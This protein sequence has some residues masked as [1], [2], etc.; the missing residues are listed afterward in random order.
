[1]LRQPDPES[2]LASLPWR[3]VGVLQQQGGDVL[4]LRAQVWGG[5][6]AKNV[7]NMT[8]KSCLNDITDTKSTLIIG[9]LFHIPSP[10]PLPAGSAPF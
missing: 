10:P 7:Y 2:V 1:M 4:E 3:V 5:K 8:Y 6:L 9:H